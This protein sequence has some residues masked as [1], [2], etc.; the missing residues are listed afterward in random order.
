MIPTSGAY[1]HGTMA[2]YLAQSLPYLPSH[3]QRVSKPFLDPVRP[4]ESD[5]LL[6]ACLVVPDLPVDEQDRK[7]DDVEVRKRGPEPGREAPRPRHQPVAEAANI[8]SPSSESESSARL[9]SVERF[10]CSLVRVA[11]HSP[12]SRGKELGAALSLEVRQVCSAIK[13]ETSASYTHD[14]GQ[15]KMECTAYSLGCVPA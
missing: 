2:L 10:S 6:L 9:S 15:L 8:K 14:R 3:N 12:P 1:L 4:P 5:P 7:E 13:P 11:R